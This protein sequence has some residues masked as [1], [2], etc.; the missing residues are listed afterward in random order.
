M[1]VLDV[2]GRK[3]LLQMVGTAEGCKDELKG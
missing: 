1:Y 2:E 3:A